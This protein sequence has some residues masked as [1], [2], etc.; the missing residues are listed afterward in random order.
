MNNELLQPYITT[1]LQALISLLVLF[2]MGVI[3]MLRTKVEIWLAARTTAAQRETLHRLAAEAMALAES[4]YGSLDGP[5]KLN[6]ALTYVT[7]RAA[8]LGID[9]SPQTVRAAI[10]K[11]VLDY[12]AKLKP[13][14]GA[15]TNAIS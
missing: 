7:K 13:E 4:T 5:A 1:V 6:N 3:A 15:E 8:D 11:A 14:K 9:I 2:I 10:E 12:N